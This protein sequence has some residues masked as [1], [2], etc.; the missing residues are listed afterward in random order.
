MNQLPQGALGDLAAAVSGS[1]TTPV[2]PGYDEL[3][4][5]WNGAWDHRPA[6]IVQCVSAKDV[7][8][9]VRFAQ[10]TGI[11]IAVRG[12]G[13]SIPG[14]SSCDGGLV[15]DLRQLNQVLVDPESRRARV[16]G[17][18]TLAAIDAATQT[19]GLAMPTGT[20]S[21][22]GIGGLTLGGGMGWLSRLHGLTIDNLAAAEVVLADGR[23]LR[24]D[25]ECDADLYWAIRGG[26]GNFGVITEF[27]FR[28]HRVGPSV[29][30]AFF[31]W[32]ADQGREALRLMRDVT[33]Q[34]PRSMNVMIVASLTAP[35]APFVP[36]EYRGRLGHAFLV[37]GFG[38]PNDHARVVSHIRDA[39]PPLFDHVTTMPYVMLQQIMDDAAP[40]G[41]FSYDKG[42]YL[43]DL[44]DEVIDVLIAMTPSKVSPLSVVELYRLDGA[45]SEVAE[46][47][48]AFGGDRAPKYAAFLIALDN[49]RRTHVAD[50]EWVRSLWQAL[51]PFM[52][53]PGY[54]NAIDEQDGQSVC[55]TYGP[56]YAKL[57]TLKAKYD[58]ENLFHRNAN[59]K[60]A[61]RQLR[62]D[63][64]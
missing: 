9:A 17:G 25:A 60:P 11:E 57:A 15:I 46:D 62:Q 42:A 6:A 51:H 54:I 64:E 39:L 50:R 21:D 59:I 35:P 23:I 18:A 41:Y 2:D 44:A 49:D 20:V 47:E 29:Q 26:G 32:D 34:L 40:R 53:G 48:T 63:A 61:T 33:R 16:Q 12:G 22:T 55:A 56:K 3:R 28:L 8:T 52:S 38:D 30:F 14:L 31:F 5:L 58:P 13:H 45:Y 37:P 1:V 27:E 24:T 43:Y 19:H 10:R 36:V 7:A 4:K